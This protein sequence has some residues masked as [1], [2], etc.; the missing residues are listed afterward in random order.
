[1]MGIEG[2]ENLLAIQWQR[3]NIRKIGA[4]KQKELLEKLRRVREL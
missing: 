4:K 2:I 3:A 1:M